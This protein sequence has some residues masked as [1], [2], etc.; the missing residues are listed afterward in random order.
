MRCHGIN[1]RDKGGKCDPL[2][3]SAAPGAH[4]AAEDTCFGKSSMYS[5]VDGWKSEVDGNKER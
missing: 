5:A 4:R 3:G 1:R 2:Q